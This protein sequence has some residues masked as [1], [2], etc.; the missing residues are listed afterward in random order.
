M[1]VCDSHIRTGLLIPGLMPSCSWLD[2]TI[3]KVNRSVLRRRSPGR[4]PA[5]RDDPGEARLWHIGTALAVSFAVALAV[6]VGLAW[7]AWTVL[8]VTGFRRYGTPSLHDTIG[9]A[10]LV[11]ASSRGP[12]R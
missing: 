3:V 6:L 8:G 11:F 5:R 1:M 9:V 4:L 7:L 2:G 10:Q 12:E